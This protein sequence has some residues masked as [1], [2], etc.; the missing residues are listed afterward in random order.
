MATTKTATRAKPKTGSRIARRTKASSTTQ[1][2]IALLKADHREVKGTSK[3][4]RNKQI[5]G[6]ILNGFSAPLLRRVHF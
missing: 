6:E 5:F 2:A 1:D 3:N 4:C